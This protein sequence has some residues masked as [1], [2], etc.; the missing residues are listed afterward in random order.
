M[1]GADSPEVT[2]ATDRA[3]TAPLVGILAAPATGSD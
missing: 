2:L 3:A 1:R